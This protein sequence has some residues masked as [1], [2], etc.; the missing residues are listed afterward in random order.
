M[1]DADQW[2]QLRDDV[3]AVVEDLRS[4]SDVTVTLTF[5]AVTLHPASG[6]RRR[7]A[8]ENVRFRA[9]T[10]AIG[11]SMLTTEFAEHNDPEMTRYRVGE[12]LQETMIDE[13]RSAWPPCP[14]HSHPLWAS[15]LDQKAVWRCPEGAIAVP[16]GT[17]SMKQSRRRSK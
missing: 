6:K 7:L 4:T 13:R 14:W 17:L 8:G 2:A 15:L 10:L 3:E 11:S 9:V 12:W 1:D 5:G 16:M